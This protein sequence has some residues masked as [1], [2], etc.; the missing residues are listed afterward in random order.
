MAKTKLKVKKLLEKP[1]IRIIAKRKS[2]VLIKRFK[3]GLYNYT[4]TRKVLDSFCRQMYVKF[5]SLVSERRK[6]QSS[7]ERLKFI[8]KSDK[9]K[10]K[11]RKFSVPLQDS[12]E[13]GIIHMWYQKELDSLRL[14]VHETYNNILGKKGLYKNGNMAFNIIALQADKFKNFKLLPS[15][16]YLKKKGILKQVNELE[17]FDPYMPYNVQIKE[18]KVI[19]KAMRP[20]HPT[21]LLEVHKKLYGSPKELKKLKDA[22]IRD[23]FAPRDDENIDKN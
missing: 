8:L 4:S 21:E 15:E 3:H 20:T 18:Q 9:Y 10:L 17:N 12:Y 14:S 5:Q 19:K 11:P 1:L 6:K 7:A 2:I 13:V 23:Y 22:C 16:E